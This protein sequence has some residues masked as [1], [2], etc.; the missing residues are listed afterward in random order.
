LK[1]SREDN[2]P[3]DITLNIELGAEDVEPYLENA[4]RKVVTK[5]RIP[6]FRPGKAPRNVV[7][8]VVGREHLIQEALD[9]VVPACVDKA[10][11]EENINPFLPPD[12]E[13]IGYE[14]LSFKAIVLLEPKLILPD[15]GKISLDVE[16]KKVSDGDVE[17]VLARYRL[18]SAPWGPVDR[19]VKL[20]DLVTLDVEGKVEF[21]TILKQERIDYLPSMENQSPLPGFSVQLEG[22]ERGITKTFSVKVPDE[23][24][25]ETI[26][27]KDCDFIVTVSEIKEKSLP[28]LDDE[29]AKGI[30]EGFDS[31]GGLRA[32]ILERLN[33]NMDLQMQEEFNGQALQKV[34]DGSLVTIPELIIKRE[35]DNMIGDQQRALKSRNIDLDSYLSH[36]GKSEDEMKAEMRPA[37]RERIVKN[38]VLA[39]LS[40]EFNLEA[41]DSE[42]ESQIKDMFAGADKRSTLRALK[43]E[44]VKKSVS[45]SILNRKSME[46]LV[47]LIESNST[48]KKTQKPK[49]KTA[50]KMNI[51]KK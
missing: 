51:P 21:K 31:L 12:V 34:V 25:D 18:D 23:Y 9:S 43:S 11:K 8:S 41:S 44:E 49:S 15:Y 13:I 3:E 1:I 2:L 27:G 14:P 48:G 17:E 45:T 19:P 24:T 28:P 33:K 36:I 37:A 38:L 42:V 10:I 30:G 29:F 26:K 6:G 4:Y 22:L 35:V 7:E 50:L 32:D 46:R 40:K 39:N 47:N 20:G 16:R 5:L